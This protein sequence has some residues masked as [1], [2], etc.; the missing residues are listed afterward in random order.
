MSQ[1][2]VQEQGE[3][4]D[5]REGEEDKRGEEEDKRGEEEDKRGEEEEKRRRGSTQMSWI[6]LLLLPPWTGGTWGN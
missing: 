5:K 6:G 4:E 3:V 1:S 2:I